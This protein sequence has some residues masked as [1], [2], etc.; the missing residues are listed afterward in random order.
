ML[1]LVAAVVMVVGSIAVRSR[2]DEGDGGAAGLGDGGGAGLRLVCSN[3]LADACADLARRSDGAVRFTVEQAGVTAA[4][5]S[6]DDEGGPGA[7]LDGWLVPAPWPAIVAG[8]RRSAGLVPL[9]EP[10]PVL[11]RSPLVLAAW[12]DRAAALRP[13]CPGGEVGWRCWGDAAGQV[14]PGHAHPDEAL[15][16]ITLGA[17]TAGFLGRFDLARVDVEENDDFRAWLTRLERSVSTFQPTGGSALQDMLL[18]GPVDF[19]AVATS[20]AEAGPL[21]A[22]SA[23]PTKPE[24]IYPAP[25]ATVDVL[26]A[27]VPG[28]RGRRLAATV[29]GE[30]GDDALARSGW[31]VNEQP[32]APGVGPD[33]ALPPTSGLPDAGVLDTLR[34]LATEVRP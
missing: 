1:A 3:E 24:L 19:D 27:S 12:P 18:K 7:V 30:A 23:R 4:R 8:A 17:A 29:G 34:A 14:K 28:D 31:R 13:R 20:E 21:L 22:A 9:P 15:G 33:P 26:L 32:L 10:G 11:A 16:L 5:L 25:V 2:L 6:K